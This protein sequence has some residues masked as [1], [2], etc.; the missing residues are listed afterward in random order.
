MALISV[1]VTLGGKEMEPNAK[2][3]IPNVISQTQGTQEGFGLT[4]VIK[5]INFSTTLGCKLR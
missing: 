5:N 2:V 3:C 1:N 4:G